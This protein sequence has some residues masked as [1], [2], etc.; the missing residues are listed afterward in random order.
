VLLEVLDVEFVV[1]VF[2]GNCLVMVCLIMMWCLLWIEEIDFCDG[3]V[4]YVCDGMFVDCVCFVVFGFI[5]GFMVDLIV[6]GINY[7][8]NLGDDIMYLGIVV[9]VLEGIVF[10]IFGIVVF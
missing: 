5:E 1:I 7:G 8:L 2:D 10:G 4:G 3:M 9:V 6:F